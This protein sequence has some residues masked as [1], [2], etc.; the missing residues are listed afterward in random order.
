MA[1]ANASDSQEPAQRQSSKQSLKAAEEGEAVAATGLQSEEMPP[2]SPLEPQ[3]SRRASQ[4]GSRTG[5]QLA[6][7]QLAGDPGATMGSAPQNFERQGSQLSRGG[8]RQMSRQGSV[9]EPTSSA[10]LE[11]AAEPVEEPMTPEQLLA[12]RDEQIVQLER[13]LL[14]KQQQ[15]DS[16]TRIMESGSQDTKI[17]LMQDDLNDKSAR[18][19]KLEDEVKKEK[20]RADTAE[21]RVTET[22]DELKEARRRS[23]KSSPMPASPQ[24]K[25]ADDSKLQAV[26]QEKERQITTLEE[27][28][29]QRSTQVQKSEERAV[30]AERRAANPQIPQE[31]KQFIIQLQQTLAQKEA[32]LQQTTQKLDEAREAIV[33]SAGCGFDNDV[34]LHQAQSALRNIIKKAE[35]SQAGSPQRRWVSTSPGLSQSPAMH[36]DASQSQSASSP[37]RAYSASASPPIGGTLSPQVKTTFMV[38]PGAQPRS[39]SPTRLRSYYGP[40]GKVLLY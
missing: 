15:V 38:Q 20:K 37:P 19:K 5:S 1:D 23:S 40:D 17:K 4:A 14:K 39:V 32:Q 26:V 12:E 13:E 36:V 33:E 3:A 11:A 7:S 25:P 2:T 16:M 24:Q 28:L 8:S 10:R 6:G 30:A 18:I 31:A 21:K 22:E 29:R 34:R 9:V 35:A 27:Q